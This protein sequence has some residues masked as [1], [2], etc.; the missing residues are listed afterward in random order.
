LSQR[1]VGGGRDAVD[2]GARAD[3]LVLYPLREPGI[4]LPREGDEGAMQHRAVV[5]QVVAAH[6]REGRDALCASAPQ[7]LDDPADGAAQR[8][9]LRVCRVGEIVRDIR[10]RGVELIARIEAVALLRDGE[11]DDAGVARGEAREGAFGVG[12]AHEHFTDRA[13]DARA[14]RRAELDQCVQ[15]LLRRQRVAHGRALERQRADGPA[16]VGVEQ[17]V[18]VV[19]LVRA[20]KRAGAD[21]NDAE[22]RRAAVV[23][24]ENRARAGGMQ[25]RLG[26]ARRNHLNLI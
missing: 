1:V 21:V 13:D 11:R 15:A 23:R 3:D 18:H 14:W 7:S 24:R 5:G 10:V 2:H 25:T 20:V 4:A 17:R 8:A 19:S 26:E 16:L 22:A 9:V 12:R 6:D